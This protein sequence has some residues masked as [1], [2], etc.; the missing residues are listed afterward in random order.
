MCPT[1]IFDVESII[2]GFKT[3]GID[4]NCVNSFFLTKNLKNRLYN[5]H[6]WFRFDHSLSPHYTLKIK[7]IKFPTLVF[8]VES[9]FDGFRMI[10]TRK[11]G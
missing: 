1:L 10:R 7:K 6:H 3:I 4:K 5:R 8:D 9:I 11:N 2:D